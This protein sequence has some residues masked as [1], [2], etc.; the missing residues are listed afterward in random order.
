MLLYPLEEPNPGIP[1]LPRLLAFYEAMQRI[2]FA[3]EENP[4]FDL[5]L[6]H[7]LL[8]QGPD[9]E[10]AVHLRLGAQ[11]LNVV[12]HDML[13]VERG[14][15]RDRSPKVEGEQQE[16]P[17]E[18]SG[19]APKDLNLIEVVGFGLKLGVAVFGDL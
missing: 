1:D 12:T 5:A 7:R 3:V 14:A 19:V 15:F 16:L 18:R 10:L 6:S 4:A 2:A 17:L 13:P 11:P 9:R 8:G